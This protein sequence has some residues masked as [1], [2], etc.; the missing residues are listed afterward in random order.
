LWQSSAEIPP[1][2][3][4]MCHVIQAL[5]HPI[6]SPLLR[7]NIEERGKIESVLRKKLTRLK[8]ITLSVKRCLIL[9]IRIVQSDSGSDKELLPQPGTF[10]IALYLYPRSF[11]HR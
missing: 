9:A 5:F 4:V 6:Y 1:Y 8:N 3:H 10:L 7:E 11:C 2:L